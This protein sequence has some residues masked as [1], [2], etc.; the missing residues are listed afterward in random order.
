MGVYH[1]KDTDVMFTLKKQKQGTQIF[2]L[3]L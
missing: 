3:M 1:V 2:L